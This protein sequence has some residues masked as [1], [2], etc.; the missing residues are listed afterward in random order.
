MRSYIFLHLWHINLYLLKCVKMGVFLNFVFVF[1][2][3]CYN[4][5]EKNLLLDIDECGDGSHDCTWSNS[6]CINL[7]GSY[8]CSCQSGWRLV[9]G[10]KLCEGY[11]FYN[12]ILLT[13]Y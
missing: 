2:F 13:F 1:N 5:Y 4:K 6:Q 12:N 7:V 11:T 8:F 10:K 9:E 3:D